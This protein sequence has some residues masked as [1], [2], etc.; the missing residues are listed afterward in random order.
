[1]SAKKRVLYVDDNQDSRELISIFLAQY[2]VVAAETIAGA[3]ELIRREP[4]D[5]CLLDQY[6]NDGSGID[7]CRHI[8][9]QHPQIPIIFLS[10]DA[11][12]NSREKAEEAGARAFFLKPVDFHALAEMTA[13]LLDLN[14]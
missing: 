9:T 3:T 12:Q 1:M 6:L 2:D 10:G 5:L 4:F 13:Q 8:H 11:R 14:H 7:L